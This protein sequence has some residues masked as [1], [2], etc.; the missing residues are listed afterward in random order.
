MDTLSLKTG[1]SSHRSSVKP[2]PRFYRPELDVLRFVA[3]LLVFS[4]HVLP[5]P[6]RPGLIYRVYLSARHAGA[7]GVCLFFLL[8]SYLITEL[9][10]REQDATGG[11]HIQSFYVR[12]ILRIWP[13]YFFMLFTGFVY[14]FI[15]RK[16]AI[17]KGCLLAF[18]L[19]AG[20]W[21][22]A[23][24]SY[25]INF[26]Y[27]LWSVSV[28]EQFYLIWPTVARVGRRTG[29]LIAS[30]VFWIGSYVALAVLCRQNASLDNA[31]WVNSFVQFQFFALGGIIAL[32]LKGKTPQLPAIAR[33]ILLLAGLLSFFFAD[34]AF[35]I[36]DITA[37]P[38]ITH[39]LPGYFVV[40]I[41][42]SLLF[43]G[44]FG[45]H[46]PRAAQPLVYLGKISYGLYVYHA[47]AIKIASAAVKHL[48]VPKAGIRTLMIGPLALAI[49]IGLAM[50]SYRFLESPFLKLK[51]R[52]S[53]V[54]SRGI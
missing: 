45:A 28:E 50:L 26:I 39:T 23:L 6:D 5:N 48:G 53:F 21:Y 29:I 30:V 33:P 54:R 1:S 35:H 16:F 13:L 42:C 22:T 32:A 24:H 44:M 51:E 4:I 19:L 18:L 37:T 8:S 7:F 38:S 17:S 9:L 27:P 12:R 49:T 36:K 15:D 47:L 46:I 40:G 43:F 34:F 10:F 41:G 2:S 25:L 14:G 3:F 20:N 11:I 31:I 52:F